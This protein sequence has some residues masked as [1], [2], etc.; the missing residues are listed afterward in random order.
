MNIDQLKSLNRAL[1]EA[2]AGFEERLRGFSE[3]V[4]QLQLTLQ[5]EQAHA[6]SLEQDRSALQT[7][8]A[9]LQAALEAVHQQAGAAASAQAATVA[10]LQAEIDAL[11]QR[12]VQVQAEAGQREAQLHAQ[13]AQGAEESKAS[14]LMAEEA[15][16]HQE[17]RLTDTRAQLEEACAALTLRLAEVT[18]ESR[19]Q[20]RSLETQLASMSEARRALAQQLEVAVAEAAQGRVLI[21]KE[22][23][24]RRTE[25]AR[26]AEQHDALRQ[27]CQRAEE[28]LRELRAE[29]ATSRAAQDSAAA[30][31]GTRLAELGAA[32]TRL[33]ARLL[34]QDLAHAQERQSLQALASAAQGQVR[35]AMSE[36]D[37]Q[38]AANE[39]NLLGEEARRISDLTRHAEERRQLKAEHGQAEQRWDQ[40]ERRQE[41]TLQNLQSAL[42]Q[43][44]Q[45]SRALAIAVERLER[46]LTAHAQRLRES[47]PAPLPPPAAAAQLPT[48]APTPFLVPAQALAPASLPADTFSEAP[49][50]D[51][52]HVNQLLAF[53]GADFARQAYRAVL[54]REPDP[55]GLAHFARRVET[56]HDKAAIVCELA[57]SAEGRA[58]PQTLAGL[59]EL[60]AL[61]QP[62]TGRVKRW[63][64]RMAQGMAATQRIEVALDQL[65]AATDLRLHATEARLATLD[66]QMAVQSASLAAQ[67]RQSHQT[68]EQLATVAAELA[69][70]AQGLAAIP[71]EMT[72]LQLGL[73]AQLEGLFVAYAA[74]A[75]PPDIAPEVRPSALHM[76]LSAA[77]GA[78][79]FLQDL[80][81]GLAASDEALR[82]SVR[83]AV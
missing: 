38:R 57:V 63:L 69:R 34:E 40:R 73:Q 10:R 43:S 12:L 26:A 74:P 4:H 30:R 60:M 64:Q 79:R 71:H 75:I 25:A 23:S 35:A 68:H 51:I 78:S 58:R 14:H 56:L 48:P 83:P 81:Q 37:R 20:H 66:A 22:R 46:Q 55:Q 67:A 5:S 21:D 9:E 7:R 33:E 41:E 61:H 2:E 36:A 50:M 72:A 1:A 13:L 52:E 16:L 82:L 80:A 18:A 24:A 54:G 32:L 6:T 29:T 44:E 15:R 17:A 45:R 3:Q 76:H 65:G 31:A 62:R 49:A 27:Q 19:V 77:E 70:C 28:V 42:R 47:R 8:V 53:R 59:E 39:T 11:H